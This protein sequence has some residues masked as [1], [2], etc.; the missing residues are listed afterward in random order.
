M[1]TLDWEARFQ[2]FIAAEEE[3]TGGK[4]YLEFERKLAKSA[5]RI[6]Y[7]NP[8]TRTL[9]VNLHHLQPGIP[10]R[11]AG[12]SKEEDFWTEYCFQYVAAMVRLDTSGEAEQQTY[13]EGQAFI[14]HCLKREAG[15][16]I[17][18]PLL[19][20]R[21][22]E[23]KPLWTPDELYCDVRALTEAERVFEE[24]AAQREEIIREARLLIAMPEIFYPKKK[25]PYL[26]VPYL[27]QELKEQGGKAT[28]KQVTEALSKEGSPLKEGLLLRMAAAGMGD[29]L[30]DS[31]DRQMPAGDADENSLLP[32]A[33]AFRQQAVAWLKESAACPSRMVKDNR[34]GVERTISQINELLRDRGNVGGSGSVHPLGYY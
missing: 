19:R 4:I 8:R 34:I 15:R 22:L 24:T 14:W 6:E 17:E 5:G 11:Y 1:K 13:Q 9:R 28:E 29:M 27:M 18:M 26:A 20:S 33:D 12:R 10:L 30:G 21:K 3:R 25:R 7:H 32:A 31:P 16:L 2:Q 23:L